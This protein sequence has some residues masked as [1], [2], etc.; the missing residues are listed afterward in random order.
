M[1]AKEPKSLPLAACH[2]ITALFFDGSFP[3]TFFLFFVFS[4]QLTVKMFT[5]IFCQWLDS[6]H[7]PLG[8]KVTALPTEPHNHCPQ[9]SLLDF[10]AGLL[11][12]WTPDIGRTLL[13]ISNLFK[14]AVSKSFNIYGLSDEMKK[15]GWNLNLLQFPSSLH[16]CVTYLHTQPG[17]SIWKRSAL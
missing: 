16:L 15:L 7:G 12:S 4:K 3:A 1:Y 6:N 8:S 11:C 14:I 5:I 9:F 10:L 17:T 2:W 13:S